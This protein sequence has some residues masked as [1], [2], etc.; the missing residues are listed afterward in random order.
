MTSPSESVGRTRGRG[1]WLEYLEVVARV[2]EGV[3]RLEFQSVGRPRLHR[4]GEE[5][6]LRWSGDSG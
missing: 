1:V 5:W 6:R 3:S 2:S 4:R